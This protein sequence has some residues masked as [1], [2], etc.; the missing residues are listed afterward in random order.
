MIRE[1][2]FRGMLINCEWVYGNLSIL[3]EKL[4]GVPA[5]TYISNKLGVPFAYEVIP[6]TVGQYTGVKDKGDIKLYS[7]DI[8]AFHTE[9]FEIVFEDGM[10]QQKDKNG[11]I[12]IWYD[13]NVL[14]KV[15]N[16]YEDKNEN[17]KLLFN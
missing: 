3:T 4:N 9:R 6:K 8:M 15:G 5:G 7:G 13:W 17:N 12:D 11:D 14:I 16:I 1:I 2:K 10:F